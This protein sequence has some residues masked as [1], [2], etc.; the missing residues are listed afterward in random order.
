MKS[1]PFGEIK[2]VKLNRTPQR[3]FLIFLLLVYFFLPRISLERSLWGIKPQK[4]IPRPRDFRNTRRIRIPFPVFHNMRKRQ[5]HVFFNS[6]KKTIN[7]PIKKIKNK[8]LPLNWNAW[9]WKTWA[10]LKVRA[11]NEHPIAYSPTNV[12]PQ[13]ASQYTLKKNS[14]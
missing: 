11:E 4:D 13:R 12:L 8:N 10:C 3:I 6:L 2:F 14:K 7:T 9:Y 1:L 5:L